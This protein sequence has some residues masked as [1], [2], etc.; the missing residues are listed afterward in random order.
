MNDGPFNNQSENH[1]NTG[2]VLYFDSHN[3]TLAKLEVPN[4]E[5]RYFKREATV[6]RKLSKVT[7]LLFREHIFALRV[8][9]SL[10]IN[11][12]AKRNALGIHCRTTEIQNLTRQFC[13]LYLNGQ[14]N[15]MT[16]L[17]WVWI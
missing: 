12:Q 5:G 1:L 16:I 3:T 11:S 2:L 14:T 9:F 4:L 6:E 8:N 17:I 10:V 13:V 7:T 15:Q